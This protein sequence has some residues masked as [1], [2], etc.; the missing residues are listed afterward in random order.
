[1]PHRRRQK[2]GIFKAN[3]RETVRV[4]VALWAR[5]RI[6]LSHVSH[7]EDLFELREVPGAV[8]GDVG[9]ILQTDSPEFRII[10]AGLDRHDVPGAQRVV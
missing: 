4:G 9:D 3:N 10:Q 1:M 6:K 7:L 5:S 2:A 8:A